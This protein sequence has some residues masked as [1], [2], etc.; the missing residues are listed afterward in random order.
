MTFPVAPDPGVTRARARRLIAGAI[1][2][3]GQSDIGG[4]LQRVCRAAVQGL[5]LLGAVVH[6]ITAGG[7]AGLSA[8]S[9]LGAERL[10]ELL[11]SSGEG[12][13]LE[14]FALRRPIL[15]AD[16]SASLARWPG[17]VDVA[18]VAGVGA[19]WSLPLHV[20]AVSLGVLD[21]YDAGPRSFSQDELRLAMHLA[22]FATQLLL[23]DRSVGLGGS[24][25]VGLAAIDQHA[26]VHQAQGMVM[27]D[28]GVS[29][30]E[31]LARM[32]AHAYATNQSLVELARSIVAGAV[33]PQVWS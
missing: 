8:T 28:L 27:V 4:Q 23:D 1:A 21:L 26:E 30:A 11:L 22:E 31:A 33:L 6:V 9:D 20:G 7:P 12:P 13:A 14:A 10:G 5:V 25:D 24:L 16:L 17:Y 18:A 19:V 29:L 2:D 32:R 3:P 15:V